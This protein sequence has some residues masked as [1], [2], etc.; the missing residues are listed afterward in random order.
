MLSLVEFVA[1]LNEQK[2]EKGCNTESAQQ[3]RARK[4][5]AGVLKHFPPKEKAL[6][7]NPPP[8]RKHSLCRQVS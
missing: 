6:V 2:G 7:S 4:M 8:V 1:L 3:E 5:V